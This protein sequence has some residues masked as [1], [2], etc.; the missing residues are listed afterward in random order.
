[1]IHFLRSS[2]FSKNSPHSAYRPHVASWEPN[3]SSPGVPKTLRRDPRMC[4]KR[5]PN[6]GPY[7]PVGSAAFHD[8]ALGLYLSQP[9]CRTGFASSPVDRSTAGPD[10][11][12]AAH[13]IGGALR[14]ARRLVPGVLRGPGRPTGHGTQAAGGRFCAT[15]GLES[16]GRRRVTSLSRS[17]EGGPARPAA[18]NTLHAQHRARGA[19]A[20]EALLLL[21]GVSG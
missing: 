10:P 14:F 16:R 6:V 1:M 8:P 3:R 5:V 21:F 2:G 17:S 19:R 18:T 13:C 4:T 15:T 11:C 12:C 9:P 7:H 20:P